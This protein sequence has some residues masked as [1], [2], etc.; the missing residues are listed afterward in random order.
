M[1]F[2]KIIITF[3]LVILVSFHSN[4][5]GE[6]NEKSINK[7]IIDDCANFIEAEYTNLIG[8]ISNYSEDGY[9]I[10]FH[11]ELL[12]LRFFSP[13]TVD[14]AGFAKDKNIFFNTRSISYF[15]LKTRPG[16]RG[17]LFYIATYG[18][19]VEIKENL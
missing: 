9:N 16:P 10:T 18:A 7:K 8:F 17:I 15:H 19:E 11:A 5:L 1:K 3:F 4:A 12:F 13:W 14:Y 2:K 6:L